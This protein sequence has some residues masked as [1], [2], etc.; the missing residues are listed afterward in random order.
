M[1]L[2][3]VP[4]D[5]LLPKCSAVVH[6]GGAGTTAAGAALLTDIYSTPSKLLGEL[7]LT[8]S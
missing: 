3:D 6:H 5:W 1:L 2:D 4:H 8:V 7:L